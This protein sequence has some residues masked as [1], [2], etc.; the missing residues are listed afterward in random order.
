MDV[1]KIHR[2]NEAWREWAPVIVGVI[3]LAAVLVLQFLD[4]R[5]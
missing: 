2:W 1:R 4:V 3:A 5:P